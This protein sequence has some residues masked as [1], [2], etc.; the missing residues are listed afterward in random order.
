MEL[1]NRIMGGKISII[2]STLPLGTSKM[3]VLPDFTLTV[4]ER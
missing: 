1:Q 3:A 4:L 2:G